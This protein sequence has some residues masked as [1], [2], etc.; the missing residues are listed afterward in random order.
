MSR[1]N[2]SILGKVVMLKAAKM[3][4]PHVIAVEGEYKD[5]LNGTAF[6]SEDLGKLKDDE[7]ADYSD[8]QVVAAT[9]FTPAYKTALCKTCEEALT[10]GAQEKLKKAVSTA[11]TAYKSVVGDW[12]YKKVTTT[13]DDAKG[14]YLELNVIVTETS[15]VYSAEAY[16]VNF[17]AS[18]NKVTTEKADCSAPLLTSEGGIRKLT[19]T[20][21]SLTEA[22]FTSANLN[23][24]IIL[25]GDK[26]GY[27]VSINNTPVEMG[28]QEGFT[29]TLVKSETH[30]THSF[31]VMDNY[32]L[33]TFNVHASA[34]ATNVTPAHYLA[35]SGCDVKFYKEQCYYM[36]GTSK[37]TLDKGTEKTC[38]ACGY[39]GKSGEYLYLLV[40]DGDS[41]D[42][43]LVAKNA[44]LQ[45]GSEVYAFFNGKAETI[46]AW[47]AVQNI[48]IKNSG[49]V[50]TETDNARLQFKA[51][52]ST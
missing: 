45:F 18:E 23:S 32:G 10:D 50:M 27:I 12:V 37:P 8:S 31:S 33:K 34:D 28:E 26:S 40:T 38:A 43:Y 3:S 22:V 36:N 20:L 25:S 6:N 39:N 44:A 29:A 47:T 52:S 1:R 14:D 11:A 9:E 35:C 19:F 13:E 49:F 2:I 15:G 48:A 4:V 5:Y 24:T 51:T 17:D 46:D 21:D 42:H 16:A 30:L 41:K 7:L